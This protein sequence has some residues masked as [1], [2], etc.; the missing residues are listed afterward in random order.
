MNDATGSERL[1]LLSNRLPVVLEEGAEG[2]RAEPT[3]GGLATGLSRPHRETGGSW[4][5]W[6]GT[7]VDGTLPDE[8][9][10]LLGKHG[11]RGVALSDEEREAYYLRTANRCIWP[12]FHYFTDRVHFDLDD[13]AAYREVNKRFAEAAAKEASEGDLV[14]VQDFHLMLVPQ[15]LR[16]LRPDLRIG[17]FLHIPFPSSEIFRIFPPCAEVLRG[18]L[19][20][21]VVA[22][23]TLE[24]MRH[25]RSAAQRV[26]GVDAFTSTIPHEGREVKLVAQPLGIEPDNWQRDP[27]DPEFSA[28]LAEMR[29]AIG[30]R[31]LILGVERLDYTKG[32]PERLKAYRDLLARNPE[33]VEE[34]VMIQI[35]VPSRVE[36]EEYRDLRDEVDRLVGEINGSFGRPGLQPLEYQFRGMDPVRL[37]ALYRL[38][39]VAVVTPLRDG[40]NLVAKEYV[41]ARPDDSGVLVLSEFT[42][43]A[44]ELGEALRVNP[45]DPDA[46]L[47]AF[48]RALELTPKEQAERMAPMRQRVRQSDVH[49]WTNVC[50]EA[51]RDGASP[52]HPEVIDP[53]IRQE[54]LDAWR[55]AEK[56]VLFLDY[57]GTLRSFTNLPGDAVPDESLLADLETLAN[58]AEVWIVS[59]REMP[60]LERWLGQTG[61]GIVA[62]HGAFIREPGSTK[63]RHVPVTAPNGWREAVRGVM[64]AFTKRVPGS[65]IEEKP[66][67]LAWHYRNTEPSIGAWQARELALHVSE[68]GSG[69]SLEVLRGNKVVEVR[70]SGISK[71]CALKTLLEDR[72]QAPDFI[73][74]AGDDTTDESMFRAL[75]RDRFTILVGD[76]SSAAR[77]RVPDSATLR[78]ILRAM[79][80]STTSSTARKT[81]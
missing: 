57:D 8:V 9:Q 26:L 80:A 29:E 60:I 21:D 40:L 38:A 58:H 34:V 33:L 25:F 18:L 50:L 61:C 76:H 74:A 22:F 44:W 71:G 72:V 32:I 19:G 39:D 42:G 46:M 36:A 53:V 31:R 47:R 43:V 64:D 12:L 54:M 13:W 65:L 55:S 67:G 63:V 16:E 70:P 27:D 2:W 81:R 49:H 77:L 52:V 68:V 20:A 35:A 15:M 5:G 23:H 17:F 73:F 14:F 59:G 45:F 4:I 66:I 62:E 28:A 37:N 11:M 69:M 78:E 6:P 3:I 10:D 30:N 75:A 7:S 48:E 56:P 51:I 1:I 79:A 24:Y 41:A